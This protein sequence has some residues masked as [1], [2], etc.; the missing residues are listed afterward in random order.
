MSSKP[1]VLVAGA[2]GATG[3][4]ITH[5]L[6]ESGNFA[7]AVLTRPSSVSKSEIE[8]LRARGA[9]IRTADINSD[10]VE[11]LTEVLSG[12]DILIS[13]VNA[14][15]LLGQKPLF[16]AA[17]AAGVKRV[18]PCDFATPGARGVRQLHDEKLEIHD[19]IKELGLGYTL[20]DIGWWQQLYLPSSTSSPA[21]SGPM[22]HEIFGDGNKKNLLTDLEHVGVWVARIV[23]DER[24]LNQSVIVWE[25]EK[26]LLEAQEIGERVSGEGEFIKSKRTN[27]THEEIL[28][29]AKAG[30][31]AY[32]R[33]HSYADFG[34]W[35]V[36]EYMVSL[37]ILGENTLENAKALGALDARELY[38]DIKPVTLEGY[39]KRFYKKA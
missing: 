8:A 4:P 32:Q 24:T 38:P 21:I 19:Y 10:S 35:C 11:R 22:S 17:K 37:H 2:T 34:L 1:L 23:A 36:S 3:K 12:V 33:S 18:V 27:V 14:V 16:S 15:A 28:A 25:D 9:E 13:A 6:L 30:K 20:I 31:E 29:R 5:A 39:A 26:T 7:V